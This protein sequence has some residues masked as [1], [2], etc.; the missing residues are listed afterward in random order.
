[1]I[2]INADERISDIKVTDSHT[3]ILESLILLVLLFLEFP[4]TVNIEITV[5][6][7]GQTGLD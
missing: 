5:I 2:V 1:M 6:F 7:L 3:Y 4:F